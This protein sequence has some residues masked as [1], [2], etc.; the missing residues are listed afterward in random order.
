MSEI[1][2]AHQTPPNLLIKNFTRLYPFG[3]LYK[4]SSSLNY[5][6][7]R[8]YI[9]TTSTLLTIHKMPYFATLQLDQGQLTK[10]IYGLNKKG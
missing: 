5:S 9:I 2:S 4:S 8:Y 3:R 7:S 1:Q 6:D 10:I